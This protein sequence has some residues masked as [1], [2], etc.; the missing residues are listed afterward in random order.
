MS[1]FDKWNKAVDGEALAKDVKE[2]EE[3]GGNFEYKEVPLGEYEVKIHKMELKESK[4][5]TQCS[6]VGSRFWKVNSR[7]QSYS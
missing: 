1:I 3:N 5:V 6:H 2:V 7:I 4:K